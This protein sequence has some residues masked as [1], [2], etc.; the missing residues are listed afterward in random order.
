[1]ENEFILFM[2]DDLTIWVFFDFSGAKVQ[3][4]IGICN[5]KM[6]KMQKNAFFK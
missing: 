5:F 6:S 2:I 1:M 3:K 4:N